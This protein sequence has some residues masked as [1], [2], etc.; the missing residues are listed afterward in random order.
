MQYHYAWLSSSLEVRNA[1]TK[2]L[3]VN[4]GVA[5]VIDFSMEADVRNIG[6]KVLSGETSIRNIGSAD[7]SMNLAT[8]Q[9]IELSA[10]FLPRFSASIATSLGVSIRNAGS[11]V[12][13]ENFVL[14]NKSSKNMTDNTIIRN[15][16][17]KAL[18]KLSLIVRH[19][20]SKA[21]SASMAVEKIVYPADQGLTHE[22]YVQKTERIVDVPLM[23]AVA[24]ATANTEYSFKLPLG[25]KKVR[26]HEKTASA[27]RIAWEPGHVAA[28]LD[29]FITISTVPY[30]EDD[31]HLLPRTL[32]FAV[33]ADNKIAEVLTW[34]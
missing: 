7:F 8:A 15:K 20:G 19:P 24:L 12:H 23:T 34:I 28:A 27:L 10:S 25:T 29:P 13:P 5:F 2:D 30:E 32:Y 16:S 18:T 17:S 11:A 26:V 3:S 14:R 22:A 1:G 21:L 33:P 9:T 4:L 31:L 6:S